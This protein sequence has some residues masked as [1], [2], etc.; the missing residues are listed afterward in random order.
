MAESVRELPGDPSYVLDCLA[1]RLVRE[2]WT[3]ATRNGPL[4]QASRDGHF[5]S[6]TVLGS[7]RGTLV[8]AEGSHSAVAYFRQAIR[9]EGM[10]PRDFSLA[11]RG[12]HLGAAVIAGLGLTAAAS[13]LLLSTFCQSPPSSDVTTAMTGPAPA[14]A[15]AGPTL[16]K[17]TQTRVPPSATPV[18]PQ[19]A[20][21]LASTRAARPHPQ[22]T[23][24]PVAPSFTPAPPEATPTAI[25]PES[26]PTPSPPT[27]A[28]VTP[29]TTLAPSKPSPR[30]VTSTPTLDLS[31]LADAFSH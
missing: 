1:Q 11:G 30:P 9:S 14:I 17:P 4:L 8:H 12:R 15:N 29:A 22:P 28:S 10:P 31:R 18:P 24:S 5:L 19:P 13:L 20:A 21:A 26:T 3:V 6:L 23:P 2:G 27:R 16:E 7:A 25:S